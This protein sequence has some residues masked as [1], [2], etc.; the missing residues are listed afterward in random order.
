MRNYGDPHSKHS[1]CWE[2]SLQGMGSCGHSYEQMQ[3]EVM[4]GQRVLVEST[5]CVVNEFWS[6]ISWNEFHSHSSHITAGVRTT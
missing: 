1:S 4:C 5:G 2:V 6:W 3:Y